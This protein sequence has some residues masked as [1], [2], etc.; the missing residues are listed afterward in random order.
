MKNVQMDLKKI[1]CVLAIFSFFLIG[2]VRAEASSGLDYGPIN[3]NTMVET[4]LQKFIN[5]TSSSNTSGIFDLSS[6]PQMFSN[7]FANR[8]LVTRALMFGIEGLDE[9][10]ATLKSPAIAEKITG[11]QKDSLD[12]VFGDKIDEAQKEKIMLEL[13]AVKEGHYDTFGIIGGPSGRAQNYVNF[14]NGLQAMKV[15]EEM[16]GSSMYNRSAGVGIVLMLVT[17][18]GR[19]AWMAYQ[20]MLKKQD[21]TIYEPLRFVF[22]TVIF[23]IFLLFL[24]PAVSFTLSFF[25]NIAFTLATGGEAVEQE[26]QLTRAL[27]DTLRT[28]LE[29]SG[30]APGDSALWGT[31]TSF[32]W[33]LAKFVSLIMANILYALTAC[34]IF[35][36]IF[37]GDVM[38]GITVTIAPFIMA[39]SLLPTMEEY[40]KQ[41]FQSLVTFALY[42]PLAAVYALLMCVIFVTTRNMSTVQII[43]VMGTFLFGGIK[44]PKMAHSLSGSVFS[45]NAQKAAGKSFGGLGTTA[46]AAGRKIAS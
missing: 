5:N 28:S 15:V 39:L 12:I 23:I 32:D 18:V 31:I 11:M 35:L 1:L 42:G 17:L 27:L 34:I 20:T 30:H 13:Y 26:A 33:S 4:G 37:L 29:M 22:K 45:D 19:L 24:R 46:K 40:P 10:I 2:N 38:F 43:V 41:W 36:I 3:I 6:A 44:I 21:G 16:F 14:V 7:L 8:W 25:D 9:G